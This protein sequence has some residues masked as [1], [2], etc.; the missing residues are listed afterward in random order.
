MLARRGLIAKFGW[1]DLS[2]LELL[3]QFS[4]LESLLNVSMQMVFLPGEEEIP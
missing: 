2:W 1:F 4:W 3:R